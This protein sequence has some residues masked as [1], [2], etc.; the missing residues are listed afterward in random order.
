MISLDTTFLI[1]L[2]WLDSPRH[3]A[4]VKLFE[5]LSDETGIYQDSQNQDIL[6]YYN[7]FNE[8]VHVITDTRRFENAMTMTRALEI[9]EQWRDLER[10]TI[11]FPDETS[12]GRA[13]TWLS[14]YN[15]G[16]NRLNDTNMISCYVTAGASKII[17]AN[18]KDFEIIQEIECIK[19]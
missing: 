4:A 10:I 6:V 16:R 3:N 9:C 8:F 7:C 18:P 5:E 19:Y 14:I 1:D 13:L 17:T 11:V 12:Y 2:Y 15:L